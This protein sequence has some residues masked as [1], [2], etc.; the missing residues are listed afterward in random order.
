LI[1]P[2]DRDEP[3]PFEGM[4]P[5]PSFSKTKDGPVYRIS[6]EVDQDLWQKF[7]DANTAG[8]IVDANMIVTAR[9]IAEPK[10]TKEPKPDRPK[11]GNL[12]KEAGKI[13][14]VTNFQIYAKM[15][16]EA[17][18]AP[19]PIELSALDAVIFL[20][21]ACGVDSRAELDHNKTAAKAFKDLM[22]D[23]S[24]WCETQEK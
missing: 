7:V 1:N 3:F 13:C 16:L 22:H 21:A 20:R 5:N 24:Q 19:E 12:A 9:N 4:N 23:Y 14:G 8:M 2:L 10:K 6:F 15:K 17:A 18:G 11:G